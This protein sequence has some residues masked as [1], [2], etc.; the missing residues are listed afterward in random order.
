MQLMFSDAVLFNQNLSNWQLSPQ[1]NIRFM[2]HRADA[3]S[4]SFKPMRAR[5]Q[6]LQTPGRAPVQNNN[7]DEAIQVHN[8]FDRINLNDLIQVLN[9][10]VLQYK[11]I[12]PTFKQYV[13]TKLKSLLKNYNEPDKDELQRRFDRLLPKIRVINYENDVNIYYTV[14]YFVKQQDEHYQDNYIKFFINDSFNAY[15][16]KT[17]STSCPKGI[18]ERLIFSL[19]SAGY[20]IDNP[21][22]KQISEIIYPISNKQLLTFISNCIQQNTTALE[23]LG[24]KIDEKKELIKQ[25]VIK[26]IQKSSSNA[27]IELLDYRINK[28]INDS[29]D[30]LGG[31]RRRRWKTVKKIKKER[32]GKTLKRNCKKVKKRKHSKEIN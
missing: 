6:P 20:D 14:I 15:D 13:E 23:G 29:K 9:G 3:I 5:T 28:L 8:E 19:S 30:M 17:D 12:N 26:Q 31:K 22:Y 25:C 1:V 7:I 27:S 18:K 21:K 16:T 4:E 24:D 11:T 10:N 32:K 2:F